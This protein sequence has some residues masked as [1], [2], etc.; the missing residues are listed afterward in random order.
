MDSDEVSGK[1]MSTLE[2]SELGEQA[3]AGALYGSLRYPNTSILFAK[4]GGL[5]LLHQPSVFP[6]FLHVF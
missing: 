6:V 1:D 4:H 5:E 3:S 2:I